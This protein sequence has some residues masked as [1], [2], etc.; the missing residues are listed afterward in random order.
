MPKENSELMVG[1]DGVILLILIHF[2]VFYKRLWVE[3]GAQKN[4]KFTHLSS[5][6]LVKVRQ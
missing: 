3:F 4:T 6:R 1:I 5:V 2:I